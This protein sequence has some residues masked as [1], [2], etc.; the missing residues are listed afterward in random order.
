MYQKW[1]DR[2]ADDIAAVVHDAKARVE[3][4]EAGVSCRLIA[5]T[6]HDTYKDVAGWPRTAETVRQW[7]LSRS[8]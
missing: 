7:L 2:V 8:V 4:G 3:A 1:I 6:L 5:Y